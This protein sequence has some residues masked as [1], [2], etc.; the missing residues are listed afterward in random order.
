MSQ[1]FKQIEIGNHAFAIYHNKNEK[2]E[3]A[4]NFLK[5]GIIQNEIAMIITDE[6]TKKEII[7]RFEKEYQIQNTKELIDKGDLII[8]S[9]S[10]WY[11]PD[12]VS[13]IQ[14][15]KALWAELLD[16]LAKRGKLGLRVFGE[17][18]AFFTHGLQQDLLKYEISF[19]KKFDFPL[20][21]VCA[22]NK[23]DIEQYF[24]N[25]QLK[26]IEDHHHPIWK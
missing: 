21:A 23:D 16:R 12:G 22:Y 25:E 18:S 26:N 19:E 5:E 9:T 20:T 11:F 13:S 17:T 8:K 10:E 7:D 24:T 6:L 14:R 4:F 2:F 1:R 3:D 15:T